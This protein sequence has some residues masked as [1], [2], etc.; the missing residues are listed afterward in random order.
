MGCSIFVIQLTEYLLA[1]V[2]LMFIINSYFVP[3]NTVHSSLCVVYL[4]MYQHSYLLIIFGKVGRY[5]YLQF[6]VVLE[7]SRTA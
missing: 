1:S 6:V 4:C 7:R 3:N 5:R 2:M